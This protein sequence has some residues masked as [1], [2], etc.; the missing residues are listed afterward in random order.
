MDN[1][2]K[3]DLANDEHVI[4][5]LEIAADSNVAGE[6]EQ[7]VLIEEMVAYGLWMRGIYL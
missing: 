1:E 3:L 7:A 6:Y 4:V 5:L 2:V